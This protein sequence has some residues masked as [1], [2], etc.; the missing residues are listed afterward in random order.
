[1]ARNSGV[2]TQS[3]ARRSQGL[4]VVDA[5]HHFW[6]LGA[7]YYP[8]LMD[9]KPIPFRYGDYAALRRDYLPADYRSDWGA[10][11]V[12]QS[13]H[14]EAEWDRSRPVEET[15]WLE[16]VAAREGLPSAI[17]AWARLDAPDAAATLAAQARSPLVRGVRY[18][19][20]AAASARDAVRGAPG[21]MDDPGFRD[22]Y[23]R[24]AAHGL[25]FDLQAP[26]WHL[27][28]AAALAHDFPATTIIL[29]HTGLPSDRSADGLAAWRTA[30][31]RLADAPNAAVKISGLGRP[32]LPWTLEANGPV[33]R[34]AIAIF[35]AD[36]AM[37][38]SNYPVDRL[39]GDFATIWRGFAD[40]VAVLSPHDQA[41]LLR[42]NAR[43]FYR[44]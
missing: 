28:A 29:N 5:H 21:S 36:R 44:I 20:A 19:P 26:W 24:L 42:D 12:A 10:V 22:G 30:M 18:K 3:A 15:Q 1:M 41:A 14:V 37:F 25:S 7:N 13:V 40:A 27:D 23:A 43:R 4:C 33:I 8:W 6:D 11:T 9:A 35:G 2:R 32:G 34:D 16:G 38:A 17:V 39:A 31:E